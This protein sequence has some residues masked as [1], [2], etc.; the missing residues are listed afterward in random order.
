MYEVKGGHQ[1]GGGGLL[2]QLD[3]V[4]L[5]EVDSKWREAEFV[6]KNYKTEFC[7]RTPTP[8]VKGFPCPQHHTRKDRRRN[9]MKFNYRFAV[10]FTST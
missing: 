2:S 7:Q 4:K 10:V 5:A 9:P 8:C 1:G 3:K 6:K